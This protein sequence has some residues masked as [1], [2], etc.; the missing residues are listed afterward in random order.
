MRHRVGAA[1][2][3]EVELLDVVEVVPPNLDGSDLLGTILL[4]M[5]A[6]PM[7]GYFFSTNLPSLAS[8]GVS[9]QRPAFRQDRARASVSSFKGSAVC[10]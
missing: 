3:E 7:I 2:L 5:L 1:V 10:R 4:R 8:V 6:M 9:Q